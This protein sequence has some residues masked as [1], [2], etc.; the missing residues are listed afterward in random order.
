MAETTLAAAVADLRKLGRGGLKRAADAELKQALSEAAVSARRL[1][2]VRTGAL[3]SSI[4]P[5]KRR[6][7]GALTAGGGGVDYAQRVEAR[8]PYLRPAVNKAAAVLEKRL[9]E[10]VAK[11][12]DGEGR[13]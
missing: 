13:I 9:A 2:P 4:R 1:V 12:L 3:R 11:V 5:S 8:A 7:G 10:R 6:G